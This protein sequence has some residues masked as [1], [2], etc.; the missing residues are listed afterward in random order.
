MTARARHDDAKLKELI[1][2]IAER[3]A[4][5]A[6]FGAV[7]LNKI[8]FYSDFLAYGHFG[9]SITGQPYFRLPLGPAPRRL[10]PVKSE[11]L[12]GGDIVETQVQRYVYHQKRIVPLRAANLETFRA[13][14]LDLVHEVIEALSSYSADMA[15]AL[16]HNFIGWQLVADG[17]EIPYQTIFLTDE[18]PDEEHMEQ[19]RKLGLEHGWA[20]EREVAAV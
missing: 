4:D 18:V 1:V 3:S 8:L 19:Y 2:Y 12:E 7:K 10:L 5:D 16:S 11:M 6:Y 15:T 17:E 13:E 20:A 14:E 9:E